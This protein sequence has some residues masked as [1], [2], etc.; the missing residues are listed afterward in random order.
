MTRGRT[1]PP[2]SGGASASS[3]NFGEGLSSDLGDKATDD[4]EEEEAAAGEVNES[5]SGSLAGDETRTAS[6]S[7]ADADRRT[8]SEDS[9]AIP[10]IINPLLIPLNPLSSTTVAT[11]V[12]VVRSPATINSIDLM[13][14]ANVFTKK[15]NIRDKIILASKIFCQQPEIN[16]SASDIAAIHLTQSELYKAV[17]MMMSDPTVVTVPTAHP[18]NVNVMTTKEPPSFHGIITSSDVKQLARYSNVLGTE[19]INLWSLVDKAA[20]STIDMHFRARGTLCGFTKPQIMRDGSIGETPPAGK[21]TFKNILNKGFFP[22]GDYAIPS[23]REH[24][25][26]EMNKHPDEPHLFESAGV[27]R[28]YGRGTS[29]GGVHNHI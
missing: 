9:P 11:S 25:F 29:R 6:G 16:F 5:M 17:A 12:G 21:K 14:Q 24:T 1:Q 8:A 2:P 23:I 13:A 28:E 4:A 19:H 18:S 27:V 3:A 22:G 7:S 15:R 10:S 20:I 26:S